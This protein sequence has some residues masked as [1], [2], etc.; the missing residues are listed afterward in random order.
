[1]NVTILDVNDNY[2][3]FNASPSALGVYNDV[4]IGTPLFHF[5][6]HDRDADNYGTI[7]YGIEESDV[8]FDIDP[9]GMPRIDLAP[10]QWSLY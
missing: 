1:M 4:A 9:H 10:N 2:P 8:P 7:T 6:A 3:V 5:S